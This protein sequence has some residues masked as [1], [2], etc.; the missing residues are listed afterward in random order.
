MVD[1]RDLVRELI[2]FFEVLRR[3][4]DRRPLA[5]EIA[6]DLPDLVTTSRIE[7]RGRLVEE[8]AAELRRAGIGVSDMGLRRP[9]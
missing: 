4:Q 3:Q 7:A 9:T 5:A 6:D 8:A 1:H 2:R